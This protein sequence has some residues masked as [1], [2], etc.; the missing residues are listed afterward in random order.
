MKNIFIILF[1]FMFSGAAFSQTIT[2][3][4]EGGND[5]SNMHK[6]ITPE[7]EYWVTVHNSG[8]SAVNI[9]V[10]VT[11]ISVVGA[12]GINICYNGLC[13]SMSD[14]GKVGAGFDLAA[15]AST[16]PNFFDAS[17]YPINTG[18]QITVTINFYESSN[19]SN[20]VSLSLATNPTGISVVGKN[21]FGIYPNPARDLVTVKKINP[22][23]T[24][25]IFRDITGKEMKRTKLEQSEQTVSTA[26]LPEG[27]Y[28]YSYILNNRQTES[29]KLV[30]VR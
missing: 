18:D 5:I 20:A 22:E 28:F 27:I 16:A 3:T 26:D 14:I 2:L 21:G 1:V 12:N 15:G 24:E 7:L 4:D 10:E 11:Q 9:S 29:G 23:Y 8:S 25:I 17:Y 30:I 13:Q 19:P 6:T